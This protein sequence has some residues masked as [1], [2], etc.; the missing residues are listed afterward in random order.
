[1]V[2]LTS[3]GVESGSASEQSAMSLKSRVLNVAKS[4][5]DVM[6]NVCVE[7]GANDADDGMLYHKM[8]EENVS[9]LDSLNRKERSRD[10]SFEGGWDLSVFK[11]V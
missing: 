9:K 6:K 3:D 1:M 5:E 8:C 11:E 7:E 2:D 10:R 4:N